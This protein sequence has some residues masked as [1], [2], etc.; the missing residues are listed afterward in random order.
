M[1]SSKFELSYFLNQNEKFHIARV[2]ITSR[3]DLSYHSH[4][5]SEMFWIEKGAG[6]HN[7][8][9]SRIKL[10]EGDLVMMRPDD[11]HAFSP[12]GRGLTLVNVA[13]ETEV[14]EYFHN[15]YFPNA[16]LYFWSNRLFPFQMKLSKS[17]VNRISARAEE[18]IKY[19]RSYLQLD[20]LLL[21]IFRQVT[22]NEKVSDQSE[23]PLWL[24]NAI[25]QY[26]SPEYFRQGI[27]S[28]VT[29]CGRNISY[30]NRTVRMSF[31]K[32]L[33]ALLN[34][35]KLQYATTQLSLTGMPI[36][37]ICDNCGFHNLG[38]FY[39]IFKGRYNQTPMEYRNINQKLI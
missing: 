17:M 9:G 30:I 35:S 16:T 6:Y 33:T 13:F 38:H 23:I 36:K 18:T 15:R 11:E 24:F 21:F 8:N 22:A 37:T 26:N 29:L 14:L 4:A 5:Y 3:Q 12:I 7:I 31:G 39:K 25:Q 1:K 27:H 34:E 19:S 32:T 10:E 20:S 2:N 28:F